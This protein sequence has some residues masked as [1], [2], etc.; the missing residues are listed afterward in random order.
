M[1]E[2]T[3]TGIKGLDNI[4]LGGYPLANLTLLRGGPGTGKTSF[5]LFFCNAQLSQQKS[6]V[7]VTCEE[8]PERLLEYLDNFGLAGTQAAAEG[9]LNILDFRPSL[10]D[11]VSG[12]YDLSAIF[13]RISHAMQQ[14]DAHSLVID[15]LQ[16]LLLSLADGKPEQQ[17]VCLFDWCRARK[18]TTLVT[19]SKS[20]DGQFGDLFSEYAS[21]CNIH[22]SQ[23]VRDHLMTRYL[24]I[25]KLRGSSYGTNEYPFSLTPKG[26]SLMPVTSTRLDG[27]A[28]SSRSS[29]N[30]PWLDDMLGGLGY[31]DGTSMMFSG[32][33]GSGKTTFA[34]SLVEGAAKQGKTV[35]Y[36]NFEE[37]PAGLVRNCISTGIDL[38][39]YIES[40]R[41]FIYSTRAI[42]MGLED[43][44]IAIQ[45][46]VECLGANFL[47]LDPISSLMDM[48]SVQQVKMMLIRF[49]S[50]LKASGVTLLLTELLPDASDDLSN[51]SI[52]SMVDTWVRLRQVESN[53]EL[54]RLINVVKSR[55][56]N[57]SNQIKEFVMT[58]QGIRIEN[59]YLGEGE[60]VFGSAKAE[61][62]QQDNT[63]AAKLEFELQ[64]T[65]H[66]LNDLDKQR[67]SRQEALDVEVK[68]TKTRL[69][70]QLT[71][72]EHAQQRVAL[73]RKLSDKLRR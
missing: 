7:Y 52:S 51:L 26:V 56:S 1:T 18:I 16:N 62:I 63:Q 11:E 53:G 14:C 73:R 49:L 2:K 39:K 6:V 5:G 24:R 13:L 54:N 20:T 32:R 28:L 55:G 25:V 60:M 68:Q 43:H 8:S 34:A 4:M 33:S 31:Y 35:L 72:L 37:S 23:V 41:L 67:E 50:N 66:A 57:S 19:L 42:E 12:Q 59:P 61:R 45:D 71:E 21:D 17:L 36:V 65:R 30:L 58:E 3:S 47:A 10:E 15:S 29:T 9:R 40:G 38:A 27:V 22:L 64:Q 48:G 44:L 46:K 69:E 70:H